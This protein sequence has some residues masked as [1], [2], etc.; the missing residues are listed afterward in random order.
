MPVARVLCAGK[1]LHLLKIRCTVLIQGG[2]D[3]IP[4]ILSGAETLLRTQVFD[5]VIISAWMTNS[6][7]N[8]IFFAAGKTTTLSLEGFTF[9]YDLLAKVGKLLPPPALGVRTPPGLVSTEAKAP[10]GE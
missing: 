8:G 5:L 4:A 1:D 2:Y 3:A 6:E 7:R 9:A 10:L